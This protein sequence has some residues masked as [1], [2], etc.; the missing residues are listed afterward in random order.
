VE[1]EWDDEKAASNLVKHGV[2]FT[3]AATVFS[4]PLALTYYD[5]DH[6]DD[7]DRFITFGYSSEGRL[8]VVSHTDRG[9]RTRIIS[10]RPATRREK[11]QYEE[12]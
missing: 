7:E 3:E 6:S 4:D 11:K 8:L 5:P 1:F 10:S 12:G 2:L 9:I